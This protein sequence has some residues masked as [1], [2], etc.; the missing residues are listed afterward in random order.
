[1]ARHKDATW[2]LDDS[3]GFP[4]AQLAALMDIRDELKQIKG[5]LQCHRIPR[6][7]DAMVRL[8]KR[9]A[10]RNPLKRGRTK[11]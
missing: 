3:P 10:K 4:G 1:M 9:M 11:T 5:L 2:N 8:D 7:L 6:G